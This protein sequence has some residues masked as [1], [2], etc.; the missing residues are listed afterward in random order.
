METCGINHH[1]SLNKVKL[2]IE[3]ERPEEVYY[4]G[5]YLKGAVKVETDDVVEITGKIFLV[6]IID[7][8]GKDQVAHKRH[9]GW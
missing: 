2:R 5:Q 9:T 6:L 8:K 4:G 3:L 1:D 7:V